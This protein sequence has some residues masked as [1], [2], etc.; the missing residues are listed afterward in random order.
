M[1]AITNQ[2][3]FTQS[4]ANCQS[5]PAQE[6]EVIPTKMPSQRR[7]RLLAIAF[8]LFLTNTDSHKYR[9]KSNARRLSSSYRPFSKAVMKIPN[10]NQQ[11]K[12]LTDTQV[13]E[14]I[15][16]NVHE[17]K[18]IGKGGQYDMDMALYDRRKFKERDDVHLT[19]S[20][21]DEVRILIDEDRRTVRD[22]KVTHLTFT[23]VKAFD[24]NW[25][26]AFYYF[27]NLEEVRIGT[28]KPKP[29]EMTDGMQILKRELQMALAYHR[30]LYVIFYEER[31]Y[32]DSLNKQP[33]ANC[34]CRIL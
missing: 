7:P 11:R 21:F 8:L 30:H 24:I 3:K 28:L 19:F 33:E 31:L 1:T 5:K 27:A 17:I 25:S 4:H 2:Q 15:H 26:A 34:S 29:W 10:E 14:D 18:A 22:Y 6:Y 16:G 32:R 12:L 20:N 9:K 13:I 23:D